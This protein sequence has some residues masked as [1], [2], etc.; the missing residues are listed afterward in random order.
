MT[1]ARK[2][3]AVFDDGHDYPQVEFYSK[4]RK[5]SRQNKQDAINTA[6]RK[7]GFATVKY[8]RFVE[9]YRCQ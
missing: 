6:T 9:A 2:Y 3:I 5:N 7:F 4:H 1:D 8:W